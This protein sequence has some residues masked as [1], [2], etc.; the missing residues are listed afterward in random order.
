MVLTP[1]ALTRRKSF[2]A[3]QSQRPVGA[4][5]VERKVAAAAADVERELVLLLSNLIITISQQSIEKAALLEPG[6]SFTA[7]LYC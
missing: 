7:D 2:F 4:L 1:H 3:K 6:D 5:V